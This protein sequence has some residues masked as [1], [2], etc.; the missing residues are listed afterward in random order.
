MLGYWVSK[1]KSTTLFTPQQLKNKPRA[2]HCERAENI[3]ET[4]IH[5]LFSPFCRVFIF[6]ICLWKRLL[7]I[8]TIQP[9]WGPASET[10]RHSVNVRIWMLDELFWPHRWETAITRLLRGFKNGPEDTGFLKR[11]PDQFFMIKFYWSPSDGDYW[12]LW[13]CLGCKTRHQWDMT[14]LIEAV[15]WLISFQKEETKT[16]CSY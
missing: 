4:N 15:I 11:H 5:C 13:A 8:I 10:Q 1:V 6:T 14:V 7:Q 16:C 2:L 12:E 9:R 3:K